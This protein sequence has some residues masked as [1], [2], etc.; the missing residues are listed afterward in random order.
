M[1]TN[2]T[3][4]TADRAVAEAAASAVQHRG[5]TAERYG[6]ALERYVHA[7]AAPRRGDGRAAVGFPPTTVGDVMSR[8]VVSAYEGAL[9]KDIARALARNN[10]ESIP[11]IDENRRVVGVVT[12]SDLLARLA[13]SPPGPRHHHDA[14]SGDR[15]R[16]LHAATARE[17]MT[18]PAITTTPHTS[19]AAAARLAARHRVRSLPVVNRSGELIGQVRRSD[20]VKVFLREDDDILADV[21]R[22]VI[23]VEPTAM[24]GVEVQVRDGVVTF[25]GRV[26]AP[27]VA[28]RL[29]TH[30]HRVPGV[31]EVVDQLRR[32]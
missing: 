29:V 24:A 14:S 19:I 4:D 3:R 27:A 8:P 23:R 5:P 16:K 30:A 25:S 2:A 11:V 18:S 26:G 20:L 22:D 10:V 12:V 1:A 13:G 28:N 7:V 6:S 21:R 15:V 31:V 17:L 32:Y 9:F